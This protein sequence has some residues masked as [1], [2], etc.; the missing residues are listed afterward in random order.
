MKIQKF[1]NTIPWPCKKVIFHAFI[2]FNSVF[3]I[4]EGFTQ[5]I[6]FSQFNASPFNLNPALTGSF[7]GA[8]RFI[9]N[10]RRQWASVTVPYQTFGISADGRDL[11]NS[12]LNAGITV[13]SD[14]AGDSEFGTF[15]SG[16]SLGYA[17]NLNSDSSQKLFFGVLPGI[18]QRKVNY[19][20]LQFDNQYNG[21]NFDPSIGNN[22]NFT[23]ENRIFFNAATG[24]FWTYKIAERKIISSGISL[25]NLFKPGQSYFDNNQIRLDRRF[26]FHGLAQINLSEK[27]DLLPGFLVMKQGKFTEADIGSSIKYILDAQPF[28]YRALFAGLYTRAKDAGFISVGMDYD[29]WNAGLSYDINYSKLRPASN[30]R[31]GLEVSVVYI[32]RYLPPKRQPQK[33]CP[34]YL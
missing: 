12:K 14:K 5:D 11:F 16:I 32:I 29:N 21:R 20:N 3:F 4:Y 10:E 15:Q 34:D 18:T 23:R 2:F 28:H 6:H 33:I 31:G 7:E 1:E 19:G 27:I 8:Y 9:G 24:I 30:L 22:E 25:Y 13:F 17:L 26:N